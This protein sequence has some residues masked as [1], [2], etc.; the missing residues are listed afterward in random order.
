MNIF[1][2]FQIAYSFDQ[3]FSYSSNIHFPLVFWKADTY[4]EDEER[5]A[6]FDPVSF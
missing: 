5:E 6:L 1:A 3:L 4:F 2:D